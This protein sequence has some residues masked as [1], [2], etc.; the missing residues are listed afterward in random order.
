MFMSLVPQEGGGYKGE[1]EKEKGTIK[2]TEITRKD[3]RMFV[4]KAICP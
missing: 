4:A 1:K 3:S 2:R